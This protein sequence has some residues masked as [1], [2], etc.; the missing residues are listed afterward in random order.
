MW[1]DRGVTGDVGKGVVCRNDLL[2]VLR[3]QE[4]LRSSGCELCVGVD[5]ENLAATLRR[6]GAFRP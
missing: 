1:D 3:Q 4:V 5:E 2:N 6:F